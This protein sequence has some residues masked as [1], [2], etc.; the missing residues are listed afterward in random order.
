M[1]MMIMT[2]AMRSVGC[3]VSWLDVTVMNLMNSFFFVLARSLVRGLPYLHKGTL[4]YVRG[5]NWR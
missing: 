2:T 4:L 3:L 1:M 5:G